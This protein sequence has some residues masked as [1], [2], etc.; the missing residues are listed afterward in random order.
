[1]SPRPVPSGH[2]RIEP[3]DPRLAWNGRT[4]VS[5]GRV[6]FDWPGVSLSFRFAGPSFALELTDGNNDYDLT[7]DGTAMDPWRTR[8]G[9]TLRTFDGLRDGEHEFRISK[10]TEA[11]YGE[12]SLGGVLLPEGASLLEPPARPE[13]RI[14][15]VGDSLV[16]G[17]GVEGNDPLCA[18]CRAL[19]NVHRSYA[20]I[21]A[22]ELG[23]EA[24]Y[25][26]WSGKGIVRNYGDPGP[27][28]L[29]TLPEIQGRLLA[30]RAVPFHDPASWTPHLVVLQCGANDFST[31]PRAVP[32]E[33]IESYSA[34]ASRILSPHPGVRLVCAFSPGVPPD[35]AGEAVDRIRL[36]TGREVP[37]VRWGKWNVRDL[38]C[39]H[40]PN[41]RAQAAMAAELL[42]AVRTLMVW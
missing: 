2:F 30:G 17:Y 22:S 29:E 9:E 27:R 19:E 25:I 26:A 12:A 23:A 4:L 24:R 38:G 42:P 18:G 39:D 11:S 37:L 20:G 5:E 3:D 32:A 35:P 28:G 40:H 16:C 36:R 7:L 13:R 31:E 21:L 15:F 33:W 1:M 14:E 10:R 41:V 6:R 34:L 8:A